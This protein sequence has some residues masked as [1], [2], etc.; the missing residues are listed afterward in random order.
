MAL[1][2]NPQ[3]A[4]SVDDPFPVISGQQGHTRF[5]A[6]FLGVGADCTP[7]D[8]G[9]A[10]LRASQASEAMWEAIFMAWPAAAIGFRLIDVSQ[11]VAGPLRDP[12]RNGAGVQKRT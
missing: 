12:D 1:I 7:K 2:N 11:Q 9:L 10:D 5:R 6:Q 8:L 4:R 3:A